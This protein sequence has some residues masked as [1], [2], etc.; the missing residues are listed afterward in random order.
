VFQSGDEASISN[1]GGVSERFAELAKNAFFFLES[2]R[3]RLAKSEP[4]WVSY[5]SHRASV[6]VIWD[7]RSGELDAYVGLLPRTG[8]S[9]ETYSLADVRGVDGVP[10]SELRTPQVAEDRLGPFVQKLAADLRT[11]AQAALGGD[12]TYFRRLEA[13]RAAKSRAYMREMKLRQV[14][15]EAD[16]A[17]RDRKFDRIV[18]LYTSVEGDLTESESRKLDYARRHLSD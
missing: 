16:K 1:G 18:S 8:Q 13:F 3:F 5:E 15:S 12:P 2:V 4:G 11:H 17:W 10:E 9:H 14:R 6:D 7:A